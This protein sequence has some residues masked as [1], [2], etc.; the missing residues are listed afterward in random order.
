MYLPVGIM[1]ITMYALFSMVHGFILRP[2]ALPNGLATNHC[3]S[4]G[5]ATS[6]HKVFPNRPSVWIEEAEEDFVDDEENLEEGE[7]CIRSVKA[8]ATPLEPS[9]DPRF[10]CAGAL[11]QRPPA[12]LVCDAWTADSILEEG[13]PNLQF[14]GALQ[15]LDDLLLCHL[16]RHSENTVLGLQTFVVKCGSLESDYTCA[17]YMAAKSRGFRPLQELLR[18]NSIYTLSH[19]SY[20][21][22]GMVLDVI[23]GRKIYEQ[24]ATCEVGKLSEKASQMAAKIYR[25]LPDDD[26]IQRCTHKRFTAPKN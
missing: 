26:T 18:V 11:V 13:G 3:I 8:F 12:S 20:D 10:L 23:Q 25:R 21:L 2:I 24:M 5:T 15:V 4:H 9:E 1:W 7:V 19:Y 14:Q 22:D 16:E 6:S 17:S